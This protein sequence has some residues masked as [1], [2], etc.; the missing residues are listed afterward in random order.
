M[1][2]QRAVAVDVESGRGTMELL[3]VGKNFLNVGF[4]L[5]LVLGIGSFLGP[6]FF[7]FL[8]GMPMIESRTPPPGW[9]PK[10]AVFLA[11]GLGIYLTF[12]MEL[13]GL[14]RW[15]EAIRAAIASTIVIAQARIFLP[16]RAPGLL[17]QAMRL[18][19]V[20]TL[21]GLWIIPIWPAY[22]VAAMHVLFIGG[23]SLMT[24]I[25]STRVSLGHSG[26]EHLFQTRLVFSGVVALLLTAA[27]VLRGM[28]DANPEQ[29][30]RILS[31]G[32]LLWIAG[33]VLWACVILPKLF[34][35]KP[36]SDKT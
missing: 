10:A 35:P 3:F 14:Q 15:A 4:V 5:C 36:D 13:R 2:W 33:A 24:L 19:M 31:L 17:P 27:T 34:F 28:A 1:W 25:V 12:W 30:F 21:A 7:G 6:R 11:A 26:F 29:Y 18:A 20:L 16:L 23:F 9:W 22:R 8:E 32:S